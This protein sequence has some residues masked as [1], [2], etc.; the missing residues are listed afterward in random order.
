MR[1]SAATRKRAEA[2]RDDVAEA[3]DDAGQPPPT[4][5]TGTVAVPKPRPSN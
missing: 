5:K 3:I 1:C 2:Q 4:I